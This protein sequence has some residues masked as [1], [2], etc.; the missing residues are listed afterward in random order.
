MSDEKKLLFNH[1]PE[2]VIGW[3]DGE[4]AHIK[5]GV[6]PSEYFGNAV[7]ETETIDGVVYATKVRLMN[8]SVRP[9]Q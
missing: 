9:N 4:V 2:K 5:P 6:V 1:D 8:F 7:E 3:W